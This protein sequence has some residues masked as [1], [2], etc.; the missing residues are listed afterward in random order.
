MEKG[1]DNKT[2]IQRY[3][4]GR[5]AASRAT[6]IPYL[7]VAYPLAGVIIG[8][9]LDSKFKTSPLWILVFVFAGMFEAFREM[10]RIA[11]AAEKEY[12]REDEEKRKK[13]GNDG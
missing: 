9:W 7:F 2:K 3:I 4:S 5:A 1:K 6:M 12:E 11:K 13:G 8:W 10:L